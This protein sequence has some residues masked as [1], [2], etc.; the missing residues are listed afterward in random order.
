MNIL[1]TRLYT[2][3]VVGYSS[4]EK[5]SDRNHTVK[6]FVNTLYVLQKDKQIQKSLSTTTISHIKMCFTYALTHLD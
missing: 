4:I 5:C 1:I 2:K 3:K 6:N